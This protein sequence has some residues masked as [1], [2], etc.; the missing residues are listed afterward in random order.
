MAVEPFADQALRDTT[1]RRFL[2]ER[3]LGLDDGVQSGVKLFIRQANAGAAVI[4]PHEFN[5]LVLIQLQPFFRVGR[6]KGIVMLHR[7]T[8]RCEPKQSWEAGCATSIPHAAR[9]K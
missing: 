6:F 2:S 8:P 7:S 5:T 1:R 3:D 4:V 9:R